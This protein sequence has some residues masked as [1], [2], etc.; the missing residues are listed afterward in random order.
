MWKKLVVRLGDSTVMFWTT[1]Q[2]LDTDA[3]S[4]FKKT[5]EVPERKVWRLLKE[6]ANSLNKEAWCVLTKK[7]TF[8]VKVHEHMLRRLVDPALKYTIYSRRRESLPIKVRE[9]VLQ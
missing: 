1:G 3:W 2:A 8:A 4:H 6:K 5:E 9:I 7:C